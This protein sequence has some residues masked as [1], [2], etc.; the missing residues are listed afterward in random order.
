MTSKETWLKW[1]FRTKICPHFLKPSI[2]LQN[3]DIRHHM[4]IFAL[5]IQHI[6]EIPEITLVISSSFCLLHSFIQ[7]LLLYA[8]YFLWEERSFVVVSALVKMQ[9]LRWFVGKWWLWWWLVWLLTAEVRSLI[10]YFLCIY[11]MIDNP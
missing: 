10:Y 2:F 11:F 8:Y 3:L 5:C 9:V 6:F 1:C 7:L 4:L